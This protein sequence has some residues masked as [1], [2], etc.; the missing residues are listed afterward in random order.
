MVERDGRSIL[1]AILV[2]GKMQDGFGD[3][4]V[5]LP[6]AFWEFNLNASLSVLSV[7]ERTLRYN[8]KNVEN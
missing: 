7:S 8:F 6:L 4:A 2:S 1:L 5:C 3:F